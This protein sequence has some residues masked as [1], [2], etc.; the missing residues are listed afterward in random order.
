MEN[1]IKKISINRF[2]NGAVSEISD[3]V[4]V[5]EQLFLYRNGQLIAEFHCCDSDIQ[6]LVA[7]YLICN[8]IVCYNE[9]YVVKSDSGKELLKDYITIE[10]SSKDETGKVRITHA[11]ALDAV[12]N[13]TQMSEL[14]RVTGAVHSSAVFYNGVISCFAEDISR[15]HAIEKTIGKVYV[16]GIRLSECA[17]ICSCRVNRKIAVM[18]RNSGIGCI[19]SRSAVSDKAIEICSENGVQLIGFARGEVCNI[20]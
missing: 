7:G 16:N 8:A 11:E 4:I 2:K 12:S 17:L 1:R 14:F 15:T 5:E 6:E 13:F 18:A 9:L 20:Y 10:S 19:V 3:N